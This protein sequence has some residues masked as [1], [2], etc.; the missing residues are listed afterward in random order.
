MLASQDHA[1]PALS[2]VRACWFAFPSAPALRS[3]DSAA[4]TVSGSALFAG[5]L[6]TMT[7]LD[8]PRPC[9][10]GY[11]SSP[12]RCGPSLSRDA[13]GQRR[14]LPA[15]DAI[16]LHVMWPLTPTGR[17]HLAFV[18]ERC[19][20]CCLRASK[21]SRPLRY[22]TFR[23]SIPHPMQQLCTLRVRHCCRLTQHSLPGGPLRPYPGRTCTGWIAPAFG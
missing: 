23:G 6:A 7:G 8:F 16:R 14:D 20:T 2:P 15:S 18:E 11:G 22:L 13:D 4:D 9:I 5:F 21:N 10:I 3:T 12:S 1:Y 19:R 17:R